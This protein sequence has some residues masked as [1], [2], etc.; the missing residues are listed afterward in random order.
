MKKYHIKFYV[1]MLFIYFVF[2]I[3]SAKQNSKTTKSSFDRLTFQDVAGNYNNYQYL[4]SHS[5][6]QSSF[7]AISTDDKDGKPLSNIFKDDNTYWVSRYSNTETFQ[8]SIFINFTEPILLEAFIYGAAYRSGKLTREY[9]GFP[10]KLK[11]YSSSNDDGQLSL[12][13]IFTGTPAYPMKNAQFVFKEPVLCKRIQLEFSEVT[14]DSSFS[15]GKPNAVL[16]Y[17]RLIKNFGYD[18]LTYGILEGNNANSNY[19]NFHKIPTSKFKYSSTGDREGHPISNAFDNALKKSF[20]VSDQPNSD[21]FHS[22][23]FVNFTEPVFLEAFH[24]AAAYRTPNTRYYDGYPTILGLYVSQNDQE[25][26]LHSMFYGTPTGKYDYFQF[27]L[28]KPVL[29]QKLQLEF[30]DVTPDASFSNNAKNAV[31]AEI[32]FLQSFANEAIEFEPVNGFYTDNDYLNSRKIPTDKFEY[33]ST[34]D[35]EGYP[36]QNA[37][38]EQTGSYWIA[39]DA[40][41]ATFTNSIFITFK[42]ATV[43]EAILYDSSY[44]TS[45]ETRTYKGFPIRFNV[46]TAMNADDDFVLNSAF[47][48]TPVYPLTRAQFVLPKPVN[49]TKVKLEFAKVT[50]ND[51]CNNQ[52]V[53]EV[54]NFILIQYLGYDYIEY[55]I[56]NGYIESHVVPF[57]KFNYRSTGDRK[58]H[59]IS[60][61][62]DGAIKDSY[63]VSDQLI[64]DTFHS[65]I[66]VNFTEPLLLE[67]FIIYAAYR[68]KDGVREY[69][70]Y[71]LVLRVKTAY[72]D[73]EPLKTAVTF[74]GSPT[75]VYENFLF[76]LKNPVSCKKLQLEFVDVT[77]DVSFSSGAKAAVTADIKI[78]ADMKN[79][80]EE[81]KTGDWQALHIDKNVAQD[82]IS[83]LDFGKVKVVDDNEDYLFIVEKKFDFEEVNFECKEIET[84]AVRSEEV[85]K[86][87]IKKCTF[88]SCKVKNSQVDGGAIYSKNS[89]FKCELSDFVNCN[90]KEKGSGGG[91]F[92]VLDKPVDN[93][94]SFEKCTF[95]ECKASRG[96]GLFIYST[97]R[98]KPITIK[99]CKFISNSL[100]KGESSEGSGIY[101]NAV[102]CTVFYCTFK[103]NSGGSS[104]KIIE[105]KENLNSKVLSSSFSVSVFQCNF[106]INEN[107][108]SSLSYSGNHL[109]VDV[110]NC[111]F[112]GKPS[113][114]AHHINIESASQ[115]LNQKNIRIDLCKFSSDVK[116]SINLNATMFI[117]LNSQVFNFADNKQKNESIK[118]LFNIYVQIMILLAG[119]LIAAAITIILSFN[120]E[121]PDNSDDNNDQRGL[122]SEQI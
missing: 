32:I 85:P 16:R 21:T 7:N 71:P 51:R 14:G 84:S 103:K 54:G 93:E 18:N 58:D 19:V 101:L 30:I 77:P 48:G 120:V 115:N 111:I 61:A 25:L 112:T 73:D 3:V 65:S 41:S 97:V 2:L 81:I 26:K 67:G 102:R 118:R 108:K 98:D 69:D 11:V 122:A 74:S 56:N 15:N 24:I 37:F 114:G 40:N 46:Y 1:K 80:S 107:S 59:P 4:I 78:L 47:V 66:F 39:K 9:D 95:S 52:E 116:D 5:I 92:F 12:H 117:D 60:L 33:S 119:V 79:Y 88:E 45:G 90:T 63:W 70:G 105:H 28:S 104:F 75:G 20:W 94:V 121:V 43:L 23:I 76:E 36:L 87:T 96:A 113:K 106:E 86:V 64:S 89:G 49:C 6:P 91:I 22:S 72:E 13:T 8:S 62:F 68:T 35:R 42:E 82:K 53:P 31:T 38:D 29:C 100:F 57:S 44:S 109:S 34:G 50:T 110:K 17:L 55:K 83:N 99:R 27:V 10:T